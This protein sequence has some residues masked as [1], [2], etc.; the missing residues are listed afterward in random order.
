MVFTGTAQL[1]CSRGTC[2]CLHAY[3]FVEL[4]WSCAGAPRSGGAQQQ[5]AAPAQAAAANTAPANA[6]Q[7][8]PK[9]SLLCSTAFS[10]RACC[11]PW[12]TCHCIAQSCRDFA[13]GL[14]LCHVVDIWLPCG[15]VS[16]VPM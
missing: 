6:K 16:G 4:W 13:V 14:T 15:L 2:R 11:Y 9:V 3:A 10:S 8:K 12:L 7:R 5:Q 1:G